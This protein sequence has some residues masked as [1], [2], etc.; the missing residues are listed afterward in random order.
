MATKLGSFNDRG[1]LFIALII[2]SVILIFFQAVN[3]LLLVRFRESIERE[4]GI[5]KGNTNRLNRE[6]IVRLPPRPY[7]VDD[8]YNPSKLNE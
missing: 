8:S 3:A 2:L 6:I 4:V 5:L 7:G 1:T